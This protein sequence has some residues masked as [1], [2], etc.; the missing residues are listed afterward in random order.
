MNLSSIG[1]T[2]SS[3]KNPEIPLRSWYVSSSYTGATQNGGINT[4]WTGLSQ[5]HSY[6]FFEPGDAILFKKGDTFY[7]QLSYTTTA[8]TFGCGFRWW[9]GYGGGTKPSGTASK[10]ITFSSYGTG[11]TKPNFLFPEIYNPSNQEFI[12]GKMVLH[13]ENASYIIIDGLQFN[14]PRYPAVPKVDPALTGQAI[15]LGE[16]TQRCSNIIVRNCYM[17]NIGMGI[18]F[19][20]ENNQIYNNVME[21]FGNFYAYTVNGYAAN[22]IQST[23]QNNY[24]HNNYIKGSSHDLETFNKLREFVDEIDILFIDGDHSYDGV[25]L[26]FEMY[27]KLVKSGGYIIFDDYN[28]YQYSPKVKPAVDNIVSNLK[29]SY[30]IIGTVKNTL[31]ARP[32][33]LIDGNCFIIQK[34]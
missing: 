24:I 27:S 9:N 32:S 18:T 14:D 11:T 10:Y 2:A 19:V 17:N 4:P 1:F 21:N 25:I 13:F 15:F 23:G 6:N 28:D 12:K 31:G 5:I 33:H 34:L 29:N 3:L 20:G 30:N 22:G 26:D 8:C 7:S 16:N